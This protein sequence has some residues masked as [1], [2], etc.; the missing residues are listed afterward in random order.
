MPLFVKPNKNGSSYG[1]TKVKAFDRLQEAIELAFRYDD[2]VIV[3]QFL[4][5]G[6][7]TNGAV[8]KDRELIVLPI[9]EI[10]SENEFFD[11]KAKYEQE[12]EEITPAR[13]SAEDTKRCQALTRRVYELLGCRGMVRVDYIKMEDTFYFLETNT[14]P[15]MSEASIIPQ[16][17][18]AHGWTIGELLDA[19][20]EEAIG[21][22]F[23]NVM[24]AK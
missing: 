22:H 2:E 8:R 16:Q 14:I 4:N 11:F 17:T 15:G 6:E 23:A 9:T 24:P 1:V 10:V 20:V 3:E 7:F 21:T 19:I 12:S 13:L 18:L 5:G